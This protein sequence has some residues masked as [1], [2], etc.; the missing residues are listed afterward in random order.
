MLSKTLAE[1]AAWD[2]VK[3]HNL[4]M[5]AVNPTM[6]LGPLLQASMNSSNELLLEYL[7]GKLTNL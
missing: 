7:N 4:S 2:F 5:V 3:D 6:V 1:L